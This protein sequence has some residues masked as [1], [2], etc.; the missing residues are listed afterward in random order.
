MT[1]RIVKSLSVLVLYLFLLPEVYAQ[2][3]KITIDLEKD[4][5]E[6]F[7]NK[8]LKSEKTGNKKFTLPRRFIQNTVTHYNYYYKKS[9]FKSF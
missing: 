2:L 1:T 5:P 6:K 3:G 4:K 8:T 7:K 9:F